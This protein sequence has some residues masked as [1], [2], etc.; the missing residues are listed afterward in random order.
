MTGPVSQY[1]NAASVRSVGFNLG[2]EGTS[3][4]RRLFYG[5]GVTGSRARQDP[6]DGALP[7]PLPAAASVFG[8]ARL[9]FDLGGGLPTLALAGRFAGK[10]P[11]ALSEFSP[12]PYAAPLVE[13]RAAVT[14]AFPGVTGLSYRLTAD[15][16][17]TGQTPYAAGPLTSPTPSYPTQE[18]MPLDSFRVGVG[19]EYRLPL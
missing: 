12:T 11:I 10:R 9:A 1:A 3:A 7:A 5:F 4:S 6:G 13:L 17:L 16:L 14:G 15:G 8:N 2:F 19:L 18:T